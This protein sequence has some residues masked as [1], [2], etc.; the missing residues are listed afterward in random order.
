MAEP[1]ENTNDNIAKGKKTHG[2]TTRRTTG[3]AGAKSKRPIRPRKT[4]Q[5]K[6]RKRKKTA[7]HSKRTP[8]ADA[9]RDNGA[10]Q[11]QP[12]EPGKYGFDRLTDA[13]EM[14]LNQETCEDIAISLKKQVQDGKASSA[15]TLMAIAEQGKRKSEMEK[16][17]KMSR[18]LIQSFA[19]QAEYEEPARHDSPTDKPE[20]GVI[21]TLH[22]IAENDQKVGP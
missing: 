16:N 13:V 21:E 12:G 8:A 18:D 10:G 19:G 17:Q 15:K 2:T 1:S 4:A 20:P 7:V 6:A 3:R 22:A 9:P 14:L 5:E 11:P